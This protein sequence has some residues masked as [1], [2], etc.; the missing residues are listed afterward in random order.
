MAWT[1]FE[2]MHSGWYKKVPPYGNIFIEAPE[3]EAIT[4]FYNRFGRG[5]NSRKDYLIDQFDTLEDAT[6]LERQ[7]M[8][9]PT[10]ERMSVEEYGERKEVL[11][12]PKSDI[13]PEERE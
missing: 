8:F 5:P 10:S 3:D 2:D 9:Y 1:R 4:I 11:Y 13:K 7:P 12:I 6:Y